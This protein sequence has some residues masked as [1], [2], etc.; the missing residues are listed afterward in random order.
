MTANDV[1]MPA[2]YE[3]FGLFSYKNRHLFCRERPLPKSSDVKFSS[4]GMGVDQMSGLR[5]DS[6]TNDHQNWGEVLTLRQI[7]VRIEREKQD[8]YV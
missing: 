1:Q 5:F 6:Y 2:V 8:K 4:P 7:K 3:M